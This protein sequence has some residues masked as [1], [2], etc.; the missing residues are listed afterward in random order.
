MSGIVNAIFG[1]GDSPPPPPDYTP[2]ANASA[3]SARIMGQLGQDQINESRRQ[4]DQNMATARPIIAAQT[5]IMQ[6]TADQGRAYFDHWKDVGQSTEQG[7]ARDANAFS[8]AGAQEGFARSAVSDLED[9]QSN[10]QAQSARSMA[11]MGV[12]PN[13]GRF[14]GMNRAQ[15]ILN[16]GAR[17]GVATNAR[18]QAQN[19]SFAK[20]MDVAGLARG[21]PGAAQGAYSVSTGAG[22]SAAGNQMAPGGQLLNGM[23]QGASLTG[24]GQQMQMGGLGS[25]LSSQNN[26]YDANLSASTSARAGSMGLLGAGIGAAARIYGGSSKKIKTNKRPADQALKG[27]LNLDIDQWKYKKGVADE[28]EHVGPYAEDVRKEFGDKVAPGGKMIDMI[29]MQGVMLK[30]IQELGTK[31]AHLDGSSKRGAA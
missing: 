23:A 10:E 21:M 24:Q 4:Y 14:A 15:T 5:G 11:A 26:I 30:A 20:R 19:L 1:G 18:T 22:N 8:T 13:S 16:A 28:G 9:A 27:V 25:I 17:A 7:L 31:V 12:N 6:Q 29:S 2:M 3:E